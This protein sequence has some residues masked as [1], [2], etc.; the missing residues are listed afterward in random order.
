MIK[1]DVIIDRE[2][3]N[4]GHKLKAVLLFKVKNPEQVLNKALFQKTIFNVCGKKL[5]VHIVERGAG[6]ENDRVY[7]VVKRSK[8][9]FVREREVQVDFHESRDYEAIVALA[10]MSTKINK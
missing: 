8:L 3:R 5:V 2:T 1:V 9:L 7:E 6:R 4:D 10:G